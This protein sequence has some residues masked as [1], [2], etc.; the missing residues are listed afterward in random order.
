MKYIKWI[1]DE[2]RSLRSSYFKR[3]YR[4]NCLNYISA[5]RRVRRIQKEYASSDNTVENGVVSHLDFNVLPLNI[6]HYSITDP[7]IVVGLKKNC[8]TVEPCMPIAASNTN[9]I[10][11]SIFR[12][13]WT[14]KINGDVVDGNLFLKNAKADIA[15]YNANSNKF[16][17]NPFLVNV[18]NHFLESE[19]FK[20]VDNKGYFTQGDDVYTFYYYR[21]HLGVDESIYI[22]KDVQ[23][24]FMDDKDAS[25]EMI[26]Q[27]VPPTN[28]NK[29]DAIPQYKDMYVTLKCNLVVKPFDD[30]D[31]ENSDDEED[32]V[33]SCNHPI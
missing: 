2:T 26:F 3:K 9:I 14:K 5:L 16:F 29:P 21:S 18:C 25:V 27:T 8:Y 4:R 33:E 19:K 30:E 13:N 23:T 28:N 7:N 1:V 32:H 24:S 11:D 17:I 6:S 15:K 31:F 12:T 22:N 10:K 20:C